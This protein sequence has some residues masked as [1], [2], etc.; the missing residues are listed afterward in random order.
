M[1]PSIKGSFHY[2]TELALWIKRWKK[3]QVERAPH[4]KDTVQVHP[5]QRRTNDLTAQLKMFSFF[6]LKL[7]TA[8]IPPTSANPPEWRT[9]WTVGGRGVEAVTAAFDAL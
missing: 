5:K 9:T 4:K 8:V 6:I 2:S 1:A 7:I 3:N